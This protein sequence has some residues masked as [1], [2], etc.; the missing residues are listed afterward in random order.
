MERYTF[1]D[2]TG[3]FRMKN[4]ELTSYLYFPVAGESGVMSSVSPLLGGDTKTSQNTFLLEPVSS[5][6]LHNNKSTRNFWLKM[7]DGRLWSATGASAAQQAK[8]FGKDKEETELEAGIMWH[9]MKRRSAEYGIASEVTT[10]VPNTSDQVELTMVTIENIGKDYITATPVAA[11][12]IYG[13]SADNI[14]DHRNV[15]SMLHRIITTKNGVAVNPTLTFDERGHQKNT[16]VYGVFARGVDKLP[17]GFYPVAEDFIGEGG[18]FENPR[19]L[20]E[21]KL[22]TQ[23][24]GVEIDGFEAMGGIVFEEIVLNPGE[25]ASYVVALGYGVSEDF[26]HPAVGAGALADV[27]D[28]YLT[29]DA[30]TQHLEETKAYWKEKINVSYESGDEDFDQWMY[31]V[32]FQPMLRRIYGCSFLP[33]HDYGKGGRGWRDLWQDCLALLLMN[34]SGVREMLLSNFGG[35]RMDGTNATIIGKGQGEFIADRNGITRVW[36]D[37]GMWPFMTTYLYIKQSGDLEFL[38]EEME[39]FKDAQ[40][41]RGE[42]RDEEWQEEQGSRQMTAGG[43]L[44]KGT[45]LEHILLQHLSAFYDVGE[46]G[47]MRL[48]GADWNDAL[49]MAKERGESVAFTAAYAGN[50]EDI[51]DLLLRMRNE[52]GIEKVSVL[53]E[54][55]LLLTDESAVYDSVEAKQELLAK[56]CDFCKHQVSGETMEVDTQEL[57][58]NL[59]AKALWLKEHIRKNEW[60]SNAEGYE[61]FNSYY[62]DNGRRVEGDH[63]NGVRM[64]LTGQVFSIMSGTADDEQVKKI[65]AAADKYLYAPE[66]GGYRLNTDFKEIKTDMGRMYGFAYGQKENGAVFCH[67]AVMYANALYK[68][69]F[70]KEGYK[71]IKSLYDHAGN[72]EK[73]RIYPGV[74][75]YI[76]PKGRGVYHYLTGAASWLLLTVLTEM[77]GVKG[78]YGNLKLEPK[79]VKEQFNQENEACAHLEFEGKKICVKYV[80]SQKKNYGEYEIKEI[81]M[82][83]QL[84]SSNDGVIG[85]EYFAAC[86]H[87]KENDIVVVLG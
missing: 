65:A 12:P 46:H 30:F 75:E 48:R 14:R 74:P 66:V 50:M 35:V 68:R 44:Y 16:V 13:R 81:I 72:V 86:K 57:A 79:L 53:K 8:K 69:G 21:E 42:V 31:W 60:I 41:G 61:W 6:N 85:K 55:K 58:D 87:S 20:Y 67:M 64:M 25:K 22:N 36:M 80:N 28:K 18:D 70:A 76:D 52:K 17:V 33:H 24:E 56:Y 54:M 23:P 19:A 38:L 1:T 7:K 37:H 47:N 27:V 3:S 4:P 39:Y 49:D 40:V 11:V 83:G 29:K 51:A 71:V 63:E 84:V 45:V 77:F 2:K 34:P 59:K 78:E 73:S 15:T 5:E 43:Q 9:C 26:D 10:F 82:N 62:D 32:N